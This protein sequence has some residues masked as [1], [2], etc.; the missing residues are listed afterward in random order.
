M[1]RVVPFVHAGNYNLYTT[2]DVYLRERFFSFFPTHLMV[3]SFLFL[4]EKHISLPA[5]AAEDVA[6]A[7]DALLL[8]HLVLPNISAAAS[9]PS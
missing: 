4:D 9:A 8:L 3:V 7:A 6:A 5:V 1:S 2:K